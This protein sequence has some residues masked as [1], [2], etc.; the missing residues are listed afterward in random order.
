MLK[1]ILLKL[2]SKNQF[3]LKSKQIYQSVRDTYYRK[4]PIDDKLIVFEAF[5]SSKYADSPKAIYEYLLSHK[6]YDGYRF[7]WMFEHPEKYKFLEQNGRTK[8]VK[9]E[10][11]S[12]Y[13]AFAKAKYWVVN[14]WIPLRVQKKP[15]QIALQCWHGTP[16][17]R[18]RYDIVTSNP[19]NHHTNA[20]RENDEDMK[21]YDYLISPS[22]FATRAFT[23]AFN[24]KALDKEDIIIET[25]YPRNDAL[26]NATK[27]DKEMYRNKYNIPDDK[28]VILYA[29]TWRDDQHIEGKGYEYNMPV[30]FDLLREKLSD[31]Y[32]MLFRAHNLV[33]N[34]FDFTKYSDF[35]KDVSKVDDINELYIVS[36][37]LITDYSSVFFDYANLNRPI[38][39]YMYDLEHYKNDLRG[40]YIPVAD[41]PGVIATKE[42]DVIKSLKNLVRYKK[43]YESKQNDFHATYNSYDDGRCAARA[44][45]VIF[46]D[47]S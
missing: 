45:N 1:R 30:D 35:I 23:S 37:V 14:G 36:D 42:K 3:F 7:I 44:A 22:K 16:L 6:E 11:N 10:T 5:R 46:S 25:G 41:L 39:F 40:F 13:T 38:I 21:R 33:A 8:V 17:K 24:L 28:K 31:E 4:L 47:I 20:L 34:Q 2:A 15:G 43:Y 18:L 32:I 29:P 19:T 26:I 12:Y 27:S 9:H